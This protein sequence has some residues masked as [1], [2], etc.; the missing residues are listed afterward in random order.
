VVPVAVSETFRLTLP[1]GSEL[2]E[3]RDIVA[4][5]AMAGLAATPRSTQANFSSLVA[6]LSDEFE[7]DISVKA[8]VVS[9]ATNRESKL[10][11]HLSF[12]PVGVSFK[13]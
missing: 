7:I 13:N 10:R 11:M 8:H 3:L 1:P 4:C 9:A 12:T 6:D 5:C 2:P